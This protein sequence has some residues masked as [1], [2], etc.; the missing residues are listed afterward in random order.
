MSSR[1]S[2]SGVVTRIC[3]ASRRIAARS[4]CEVSPVRT[5]ARISNAGMPSRVSCAPIPASGCSRL[6]WM[7]FDSALSGDTYTTRVASSSRPSTPSCTSASIAARNAASVLPDPVGA[8]ISACRPLA[9][10]G[11]A[12][13]CAAVAVRKV[14]SNQAW[15]AGWKREGSM[16]SDFIEGPCRNS[17]TRRVRRRP[18]RDKGL[19]GTRP[20]RRCE[21]W[22]GGKPGRDSSRD[23]APSS[24]RPDCC[25]VARSGRPDYR[26]RRSTSAMP[27]STSTPGRAA[28]AGSTRLHCSAMSPLATTGSRASLRRSNG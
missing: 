3:G 28:S 4:A 12:A 2:D 21:L 13:A 5:W 20:R 24:A 11:Q 6:R 17:S 10:A 18:L 16:G 8:A 25:S 14:A 26:R 23:T 22:E 9:I 15:T 1:Y 19:A 7:S 27:S